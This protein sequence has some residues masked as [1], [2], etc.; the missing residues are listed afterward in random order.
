[1]GYVFV[2][3]SKCRGVVDWG[4]NEMGRSCWSRGVNWAKGL[5][6]RVQPDL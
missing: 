5:Q 3:S 1:M 2:N 6:M 4:F